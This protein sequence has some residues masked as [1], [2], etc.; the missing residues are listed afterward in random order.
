M[1]Y[2]CDISGICPY[3]CKDCKDCRPLV[4]NDSDDDK[5]EEE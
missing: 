3:A 1:V 5:E 2:A 4:Y